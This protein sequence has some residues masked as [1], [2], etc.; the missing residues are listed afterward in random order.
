MFSFPLRSHKQQWQV[1]FYIV[2]LL[3]RVC[4]F[5]L[6]KKSGIY[7]ICTC[8][9]FILQILP[10]NN[11]KQ[12]NLKISSFLKQKNVLF[13][14]DASFVCDFVIN[15]CLKKEGDKPATSMACELYYVLSVDEY[16]LIQM[17]S[18]NKK[19]VY[20]PFSIN[21]KFT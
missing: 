1:L 11:V 20:L 13:C 18:Q 21:T 9:V 16:V 14:A 19:I 17:F 15:I 2:V 7:Y 8:N 4:F 10:I 12:I 3:L 5:V 6:K